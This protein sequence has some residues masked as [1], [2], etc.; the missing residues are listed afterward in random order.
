MRSLCTQRRREGSSLKH[1][2][3]LVT[4][5][6]QGCTVQVQNTG[7]VLTVTLDCQSTNPQLT[8]KVSQFV[9]N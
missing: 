9:A 8:D 1:S 5:C 2:R 4:V 3:C 7:Q 6:V